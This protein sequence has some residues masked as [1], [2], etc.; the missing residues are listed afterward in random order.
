MRKIFYFIF[1][2]TTVDIKKAKIKKKRMKNDG[3]VF[4]SRVC[5]ML[6]FSCVACYLRMKEIYFFLVDVIAEQFMILPF[7]LFLCYMKN[8]FVGSSELSTEY[9][10]VGRINCFDKNVII[11]NTSFAQ[12]CNFFWR[13]YCFNDIGDRHKNYLICL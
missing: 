13:I 2:Y 11:I 10:G 12:F 3:N 9:A 4:L 5:F 7:C 8:D 6:H 1:V